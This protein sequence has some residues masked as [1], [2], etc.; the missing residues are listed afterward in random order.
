MKRIPLEKVLA[1][2]HERNPGGIVGRLVDMHAA[3]RHDHA[4][5]LAL[6][7]ERY[8]ANQTPRGQ[9][10]PYWG[11]ANDVAQWPRVEADVCLSCNGYGRWGDDIPCG[12]CEGTGEVPSFR[13]EATQL[14][15]DLMARGYEVHVAYCW[16]KVRYEATAVYGGRMA[17]YGW[18]IT[19]LEALQSL[20]GDLG[21]EASK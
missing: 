2:W 9:E 18:G 20:A 3:G 7:T 17:G 11:L 6:Y 5:T 8:Y 10:W 12:R 14:A 15:V 21:V 19:P 4:L 1:A 16:Q 13:R